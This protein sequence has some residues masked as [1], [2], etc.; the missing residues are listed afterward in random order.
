[1]CY[2]VLFDIDV[3]GGEDFVAT[4]DEQSMITGAA[5]IQNLKVSINAKRGDYWNYDRY[6]NHMKIDQIVMGLSLMETHSY[7]HMIQQ[8]GGHISS[9]LRRIDGCG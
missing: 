7:K 4:H 8:Q 9:G 3:K 1:M 2:R 5:C 6:C